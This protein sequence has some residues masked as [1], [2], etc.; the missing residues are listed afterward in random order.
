[1]ESAPSDQPVRRGRG[2]P[3]EIAPAAR[4]A[5][6]LDAAERL[7][8]AGG[9]HATTM[10]AIAAE[11]GM[12]KRTVYTVF[13]SRAELFEACIRRIRTSL[14]RP[15]EP[16]EHDLPLPERLARIFRPE[17]RNADFRVPLAVL[18]AVIVEAPRHPDLGQAFLREGP[19]RGHAIVRDELAR[20]AAAGAIAVAD[21]DMAAR[22]L[23]DMVFE[24][25]VE[26]LIDPA[27]AARAP[28]EAD[29][30]RD[31]AVGT[32]LRGVG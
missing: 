29:R 31:L 25:P 6:I 10:A 22:M 8:V 15:L 23:C 16:E 5:A 1:M 9:L 4:E 11:A 17:A 21:L 3:R 2:R 26:R 12:S 27:R 14:I 30:R 19:H 32:F 20:A 28:A 7:L 13:A 18:R 24:C